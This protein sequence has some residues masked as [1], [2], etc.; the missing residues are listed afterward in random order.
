MNL[1]SK[2]TVEPLEITASVVV[3]EAD[4]LAAFAE[5]GD[6]DELLFFDAFSSRWNDLP[7]SAK[8][9]VLSKILRLSE[10]AALATNLN[11]EAGS[12]EPKE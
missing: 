6:P 1:T 11:L 2:R 3:H 5:Q 8:L 9:L 7:A 4:I 12:P 10:D